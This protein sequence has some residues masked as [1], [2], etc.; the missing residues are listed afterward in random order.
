MRQQVEQFNDSSLL[1]LSLSHSLSLILWHPSLSLVEVSLKQR[2]TRGSWGPPVRV[3]EILDLR[4]S[5]SLFLYFSPLLPCVCRLLLPPPPPRPP[6]PITGEPVDRRGWARARGFT[7]ASSRGQA[8]WLSFPTQL[9]P[10]NPPTTSLNLSSNP[11]PHSPP[12]CYT[13]LCS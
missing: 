11:P 7:C 9:L 4:P 5:L 8:N 1:S 2:R 10:T 6:T 13:I 3:S 12:L